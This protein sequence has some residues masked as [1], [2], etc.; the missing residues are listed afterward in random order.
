MRSIIAQAALPKMH[1]SIETTT[2]F[3]PDKGSNEMEIVI[4]DEKNLKRIRFRNVGDGNQSAA[5]QFSMSEYNRDTNRTKH[6]SF[7]IPQVLAEL[8]LSHLNI[9]K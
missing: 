4:E 6:F 7:S 9:V 2:M 5:I 1:G 8:F 3:E